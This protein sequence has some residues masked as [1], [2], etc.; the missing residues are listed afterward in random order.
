MKYASHLIAVLLLIL[1]AS[2]PAHA[3]YKPK[4]GWHEFSDRMGFCRKIFIGPL[5]RDTILAPNKAQCAFEEVKNAV[6]LDER[7]LYDTAR[8]SMASH[9]GFFDRNVIIKARF[10]YQVEKSSYYAEGIYEYFEDLA[11]WN[12]DVCTPRYDQRTD[13]ILNL[14]CRTESGQIKLSPVNP[15]NPQEF[16]VKVEYVPVEVDW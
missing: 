12:D 8:P 6:H 7:N 15:R 9:S 16:N 14:N 1:F 3:K 5:Q 2:S 10:T 4:Q 11:D 13:R